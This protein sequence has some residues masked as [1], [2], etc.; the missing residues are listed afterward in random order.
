[1]CFDLKPREWA[2]IVPLVA[3]MVW[4]GMYSQIVPARRAEDHGADSR[5][6]AVERT[7][8]RAGAYGP[9][10]PAATVGRAHAR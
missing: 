1:M 4:M 3:M 6:D 8:P 9:A 10:L 7:A 2:A 5:T